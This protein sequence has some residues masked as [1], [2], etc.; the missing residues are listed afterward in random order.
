MIMNLR[1]ANIL[2]ALCFASGLA[3]FV[4]PFNSHGPALFFLCVGVA[5]NVWVSVRRGPNRSL[6]GLIGRR[7]AQ[8]RNEPSPLFM[9]ALTVQTVLAVI[10][11]LGF[12][13]SLL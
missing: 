11:F 8:H 2:R 9:C 6:L 7:F 5:L 4:L 12:V 1:L 10:L 13:S 3:G